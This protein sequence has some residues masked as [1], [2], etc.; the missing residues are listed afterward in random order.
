MPTD[1]SHYKSPLDYEDIIY[2]VDGPLARIILNRP[3]K[4]NALRHQLRGELFHALR[5]AESDPDVSVVIIKGNGRSFSAG[6]D[7]GSGNA[8]QDL[9]D[10]GPLLPGPAQ[11]PR[12]LNAASFLTGDLP[13]VD[14]PPPHG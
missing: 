7:L 2:E 1:H 14:M 9:P 11:W 8:G 13:K 5:V 3:E 4:M 10:V 12:P 6:Y